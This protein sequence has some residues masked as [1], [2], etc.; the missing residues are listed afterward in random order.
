MS[1]S[2]QSATFSRAATALPRRTR[3][4][5]V[6]RSPVIGLRLCGMARNLSGLRRKI[7]RP[8]ALRC[9]GDDGTRSPNVRCSTQSGERGHK[10]RV[11][12]AL[13]DL[14]AKGSP[15]AVRAFCRR[16][17]QP[18]E[19]DARGADRAGELADTIRSRA[20]SRRFRAAKFV[21]HQRHFQ[22]ERGRL[23]MDAVAATDHRRHF[24]SPR[25]LCDHCAQTLQIGR[26]MSADSFNCTARVVSKISDDVSP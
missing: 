14:C 24:E 18:S 23:G 17:L 8:P 13:H 16:T 2:C 4:R 5:P 22:A 12:I 6:R 15:D 21:V 19:R 7:L 3:A 20:G 9:A 10:F 25:L 1:R 26:R 11:E